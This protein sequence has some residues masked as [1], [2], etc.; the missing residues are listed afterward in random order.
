[1]T[2]QG[3]GGREC[4]WCELPTVGDIQVQ[5][6][7]YRTVSRIDPVTGRRVAHQQLVQAAIHAP[8]CDEHRSITAGQ[9]PAVGIP[10]ERKAKGVDQLDLF[11]TNNGR[12]QNAI[13]AEVGR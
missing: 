4:A 12:P 2:G 9:P 10:R 11:A 1:M 13:T 5:P 7:Q 3:K 8:V 6:A